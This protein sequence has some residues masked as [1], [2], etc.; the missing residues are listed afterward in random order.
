ME[1]FGYKVAEKTIDKSNRACYR[2]ANY[3]CCLVDLS[4]YE[5]GKVGVDKAK[6]I[7]V[8]QEEFQIWVDNGV[9]DRRYF[10]GWLK[11]KENKRICPALFF[12]E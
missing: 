6:D 12:M 7:V 10:S 8:E 2:F 9:K 5:V 4:Y 1:Y 11:K 3:G